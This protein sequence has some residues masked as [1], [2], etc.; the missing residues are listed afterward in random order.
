MSFGSPAGGWWA[1]MGRR[2]M[3]RPLRSWALTLGAMIPLAV[4]GGQSRVLMDLGSEMPEQAGSAE[5]LKI[6]TAEDL[7][8]AAAI[9][10]ARPAPKRDGPLHP[11][12]D[13]PDR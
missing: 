13:D 1:A 8:L 10:A 6:T 7:R 3:A 5:N 9:L 2:A 4:L 12:A 11:F